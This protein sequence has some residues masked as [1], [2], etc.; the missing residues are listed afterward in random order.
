MTISTD[1]RVPLAERYRAANGDH[2]MTPADDAYARQWFV[3]LDALCASRPETPDSVRAAML[4]G[5]LP[6]PSYL[7]SDGTE[8]VPADLLA[9]A[10]AA[11]GLDRLPDWFA[12]QWD[13]AAE[14]AE[15]WE[16]YLSGH[17]VCLRSVTPATMQRKDELIDA[18]SAASAAPEPSSP[19]W[20]A[21]LHASVDELDALELPFAPHYDEL[22]F[23]APS[24][25]SVYI[26]AVRDRYPRQ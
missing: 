2:P 23:G 20:L 21:R 19:A 12:A 7:L 26:D 22:R 9:P 13:S 14:A 25:R 18:I 4:A 10:D 6:L 8:M 16:S 1:L 17:W 5:L 24:S 3:T 15:S 11:G